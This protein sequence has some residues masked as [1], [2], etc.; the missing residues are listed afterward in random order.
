MLLVVVDGLDIYISL[1]EYYIIL[2]V[3]NI[4]LA[5]VSWLARPLLANS[6]FFCWAGGLVACLFGHAFGKL[7]KKKKSC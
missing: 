5:M 7:K 6:W 2:V 3:A 1:P 4:A